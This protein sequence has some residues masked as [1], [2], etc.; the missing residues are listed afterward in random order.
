ML[1]VKVVRDALYDLCCVSCGEE[2]SSFLSEGYADHFMVGSLVL[3]FASGDLGCCFEDLFKVLEC[4][5][6]KFLSRSLRFLSRC[7]DAPCDVS[8]DGNLNQ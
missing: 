2:P 1:L 7:R 4:L 6:P 3:Y 5:R 8:I